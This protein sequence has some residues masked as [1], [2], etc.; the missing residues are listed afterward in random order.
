MDEQHSGW[1]LQ[2]VD[3]TVPQSPWLTAEEKCKAA[4]PCT[5]STSGGPPDRP[6][7][8]YGVHCCPFANV[9]LLRRISCLFSM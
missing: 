8:R 3:D 4:G 2:Y 7:Y 9:Y 5:Y 1:F 6:P